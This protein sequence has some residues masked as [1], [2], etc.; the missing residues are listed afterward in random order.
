MENSVDIPLTILKELALISRK[1][2]VIHKTTRVIL[3]IRSRIHEPVIDI[4]LPN[5]S[6]HCMELPIKN[7]EELEKWEKCLQEIP[8]NSLI[9]ANQLG[10]LG[11]N[12]CKDITRK[13]LEKVLS[14][15]VGQLFSWDGAK[16]KQKFKTQKLAT[17]IIRAVRMNSI[18]E[19]VPESEIIDA[20][21]RWLVR[22]KERIG[23]IEKRRENRDKDGERECRKEFSS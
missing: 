17:T 3:H 22:S 2:D 6:P 18:T 11:G 9:L 23:L 1:L 19:T 21:R 20:I 13:I 12:T 14:N 7:L 8:E 5:T 10:M 15:E 4:N 16:G